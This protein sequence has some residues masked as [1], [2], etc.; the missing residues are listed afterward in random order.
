MPKND[1]GDKLIIPAGT[2]MPHA[3]GSVPTG[4]LECDG[5]AVSRDT[6]QRLFEVIGTQWGQG[7]G[8]TTFHLPDLRGR[9]PRG[10]DLGSGND[11]DVGGRTSSNSGGATGDSVGSYQGQ[12][13][14]SHRHSTNIGNYSGTVLDPGGLEADYENSSST[15]AAGGNETRP[16]NVAVKYV[17]KV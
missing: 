16:K 4:Y 3:S 2:M 5:S 10:A 15:F 6:Y 9:F 17:I 11:P 8:S 13:I 7:D 1:P 14:A 12:E